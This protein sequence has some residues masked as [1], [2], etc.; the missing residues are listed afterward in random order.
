M[1]S[2]VTPLGGVG[3]MCGDVWVLTLFAVLPTR[4]VV[5]GQIWYHWRAGAALE[6]MDG[7]ERR[8]GLAQFGRDRD[9]RKFCPTNECRGGENGVQ[10]QEASNLAG[11]LA[12]NLVSPLAENGAGK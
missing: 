2:R 12:G 3:T 11:H 6:L 5:F 10:S 4:R 8:K 1:Q 7:E 9:R